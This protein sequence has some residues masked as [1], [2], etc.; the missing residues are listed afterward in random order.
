MS[1]KTSVCRR[2]LEKL[3]FR[4]L[5][6]LGAEIKVNLEVKADKVI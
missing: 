1:C 5:G 6:E 2:C 4:I 3:L